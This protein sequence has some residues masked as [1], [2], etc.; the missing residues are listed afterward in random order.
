MGERGADIGGGTIAII[1]QALDIH[2]NARGTVALVHDVLVHG[3][4]GTGTKGLVDSGLDLVLGHGLSL[5]LGDGGGKGGVVVRIGIVAQ[6]GRDGDVTAQ[7]G[8]QGGTLGV[9]RTLAVLG[10]GPFR[11]SGHVMLLLFTCSRH[12]TTRLKPI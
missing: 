10:C 7:L 1:G 3:G 8:E 4:V 5:C 12:M 11:V 2:G 6:T 9:L